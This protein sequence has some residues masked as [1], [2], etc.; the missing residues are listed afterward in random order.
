VVRLI[1]A[2]VWLVVVGVAASVIAVASLALDQSAFHRLHGRG[3]KPRRGRNE[4]QTTS[5]P[6]LGR[7]WIESRPIC[8]SPSWRRK[9]QSSRAMGLDVPAIER[10][11]IRAQ[12]TQPT[13]RAPGPPASKSPKNLFCGPAARYF[14]KG[15]EAYFTLVIEAL[16]PKRRI[17]G[18]LLNIASSATERLAR[19]SRRTAILPQTASPA[20][21]LVDA[22]AIAAV[23]PSPGAIFGGWRRPGTFRSGV[24]W[25][26]SDAGQW[27]SGNVDE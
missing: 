18:S 4:T 25:T 19:R 12:P 11:G 16:W 23:L 26:G 9:I 27:A 20:Q 21:P 6:Q 15:L 13:V 3:R 8:R 24:E 2:I 1:R 22:A 14:R 10:K 7:T 17:M 5:S